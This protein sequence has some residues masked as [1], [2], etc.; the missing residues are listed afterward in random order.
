MEINEPKENARSLIS[1]CLELILTSVT[2][3]KQLKSKLK[4]ISI[5]EIFI[6]F[7]DGGGNEGFKEE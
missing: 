4:Q 2:K 1:L 3:F 7:H 5:G 6:S